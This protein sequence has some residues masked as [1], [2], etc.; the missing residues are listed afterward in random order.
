MIT[1]LKRCG[2]AFYVCKGKASHPSVQL[3]KQFFHYV[4]RGRNQRSENLLFALCEGVGSVKTAVDILAF[5]IRKIYCE[6]WQFLTLIFSCCTAFRRDMIGIS[7]FSVTYHPETTFLSSSETNKQF[8]LT[9]N[10]M[11][12][13]K[14]KRK[15]EREM[16][17]G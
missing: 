6:K 14:K 13:K 7:K 11:C 17:N 9:Y 5:W 8:S 2:V 15:K 10:L 12:K 3:V 4:P 16:V 1:K